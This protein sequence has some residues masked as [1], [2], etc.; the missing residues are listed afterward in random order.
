MNGPSDCTP[1]QIVGVVFHPR[2][3]Q[4]VP[5]GSEWKSPSQFIERFSGV[6]AED[7]GMLALVGTDESQHYSSGFFVGVRGELAFKTS[8]AVHAAVIH[9]EIV[10]RLLHAFQR[11][12]RGS[13]VE[14]DIPPHRSIQ[15]RDLSIDAGEE[16]AVGFRRR[17]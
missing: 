3:E 11:R 6:L 14:V 15:E 7:A 2:S 10:H 8:A 5:L 4:D 17:L 12:G 9:Q 1:R 16:L 13:V